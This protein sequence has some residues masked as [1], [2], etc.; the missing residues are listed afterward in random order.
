MY[1]AVAATAI[2]VYDYFLTVELE[3]KHIWP[4]PWSIL[5]VL[6]LSTRY[7]PFMDTIPMMYHFFPGMTEHTC[8]IAVWFGGTL[9]TIGISTSELILMLRTW[10]VWR[11]SPKIAWLLG[12]VYVTISVPAYYASIS[13]VES[14][15]YAP[16]SPPNTSTC[17]VLSS[18]RLTI[19]NWCILM[20]LEGLVLSLTLIQTHKNY[21]HDVNMGLA[22]MIVKDGQ[23]SMGFITFPRA[24]GC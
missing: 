14:I 12:V 6:Y 13:Y 7:S 18:N 20:I 17:L 11:R 23:H 2:L 1:T 5:K 19:I 4:A 15:V 22:N 16:S 9:Y 24:P 21:R 10:A 3:I 8:R